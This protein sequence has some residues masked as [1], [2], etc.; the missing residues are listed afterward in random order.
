MPNINDISKV[1]DGS[2][3]SGTECLL[4]VQSSSGKLFSLGALLEYFNANNSNTTTWH[5]SSGAPTSDTGEDGDFCLDYVNFNIYR[6]VVG[7]W[8]LLC[9]IKGTAGNDGTNGVSPK[10]IY[11]AY[12]GLLAVNT[13]GIKRY[14]SSEHTIVS[15]RAFLGSAAVGSSVTFDILKNGVAHSI[16]STDVEIPA[17]ASEVVVSSIAYPNLSAGDLL[18]VN[19]N[20]VGSSSA[21]QNLSIVIITQ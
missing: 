18:T 2:N 19:I 16:V 21:G 10:E 6:K 9:N 17:N 4:G 3:I 15:I 13:G 1:V 5:A 20:Q 8:S 12:S 11:Y 7:S 14:I